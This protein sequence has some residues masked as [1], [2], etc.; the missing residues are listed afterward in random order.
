M[1]HST[2]LPADQR[3]LEQLHRLG[4][5]SVQQ[6][7][8]WAGVTATAVRQRLGRL[9]AL[10]LVSRET[11]HQGRG[12]PHHTYSVTEAGLRRLGDNYGELALLLWDEMTRIE[13]DEVRQ[14]VFSR[15]RQALVERYGRVVSGESIPER[16]SQLRDAL[17]ERGFDV[18][19]ESGSAGRRLPI[20]RENNCPYHDLASRDSL[21]CDLEQSVFS[22]VLGAR[23]QLTGCCRDG[24]SCCEFQVSETAPSR[25]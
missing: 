15:L 25:T 7:C 4:D 21:I 13:E 3:F 14:R 10:G 20:L 18:E 9:E 11:I 1:M 6:L 2:L 12:R 17:I 22:E 16:L 8:E 19:L 24:H 5:A 23:V